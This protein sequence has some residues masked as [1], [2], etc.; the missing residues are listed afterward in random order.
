MLQDRDGSKMTDGVFGLIDEWGPEKIVVVS[1]RKTGMRG[2]LVLDNTARGTGKGG[3]RMSPSL[4]VQ[5]VA[6]LA[7]TMTW[8]WAAVDL[9]HGGAKAGILGDPND[10]NKEAIMRAF[11]RSLSTE[12]PSEYAFGLDMGLAEEDAAIFLDE[13]GDRGASTGL[14]RA[15]GGLPYDQLG[16]TGYGVAEAAEAAAQNRNIALKGSRVSIQGFGA[17]GQ[18]AAVRLVE[19]GATVV[20]VSTAA[21]AVHDP[22]GLDMDKLVNLRAEAGDACVHHYGSVLPA[23]AA[24]T[25]DADIL[26]PAAREDTVND[27]FAASTNVKLV[28]EGANLPT[29]PSS[30]RILHERGIAVVPD[31]IAN[32][33]GIVAAAHSMAAR[34][35]P[36]VVEP[37]EIFT[38]IST[39]L[40]ANT[41]A[42]LDE[43]SRAG[44]TP[45]E[46][47]YGLAQKRV[48][49]A[50][51]LRRQIPKKVT[52]TIDVL[53]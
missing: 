28:I 2:V 9:F 17:V 53:V 23:D 25:V 13:L 8:K 42:V 40:R 11:A 4:T 49:E 39:K 33:G 15:L 16:V 34:Y 36:F 30:R 5:E 37:E 22:D 51:Q 52:D 26:I 48:L 24:L 1:D 47:A 18:A 27:V 45:H 46:A 38:M 35:S 3:T 10:P 44:V 50:M 7:R 20:A 43:S 6:R 41:A 21:G 12:V 32:A 29:S 31:F 14:P 19:L